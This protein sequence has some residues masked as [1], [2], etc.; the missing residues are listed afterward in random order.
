MVEQLRAILVQLE[1]QIAEMYQQDPSCL[2]EHLDY[3]LE[4]AL[5]DI[6]QELALSLVGRNPVTDEFWSS[7]V[8]THRVQVIILR[9]VEKLQAVA[10]AQMLKK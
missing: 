10:L 7:Q 8:V 6:K 2:E 3:N 1:K 5:R 4:S 9:F